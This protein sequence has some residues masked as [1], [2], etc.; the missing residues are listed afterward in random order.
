M[1]PASE[2]RV[3]YLERNIEELRAERS[4]LQNKPWGVSISDEDNRLYALQRRL[5]SELDEIRPYH[6][7]RNGQSYVVAH[8]GMFVFDQ[9]GENW[10]TFETLDQANAW[11][12]QKAEPQAV[13]Q[14]LSRG[15]YAQGVA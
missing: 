14:D 15:F 11:I 5:Q 4:L 3:E 12:A 2:T 7:V 10:L 9:S 13:S 8:K 6:A 1:K